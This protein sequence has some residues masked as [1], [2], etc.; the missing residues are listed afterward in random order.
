MIMKGKVVLFAALLSLAVLVPSAPA[1]INPN[2]TPV[3]LVNEATFILVLK[4]KPADDKNMAVAEV[5]KY[6]KGKDKA[7]QGALTFD[8]SQAIN[9]EYVEAL[10]K[11]LAEQGEE[12]VLMFVGKGENDEEVALLHMLGKW[13]SLGKTDKPTLFGM[14]SF[15]DKM[16]A[17]WAG[18]TDM[19]LLETELLLKYP[20]TDV[21]V[22]VGAQWAE[23]IELGNVKGKCA[24]LMPVDLDGKG[25]L[26]M[27]IACDQGDRLYFFDKDKNT[28]VDNA[29]KM[30]LASKSLVAAWGDFNGDGRMD[31]ASWDGKALAIWSQSGDGT[32]AAGEPVKA[33]PTGQ[34]LGLSAMDAGVPKKAGLLWTGAEG[35]VLLVPA[36]AGAFKAQ[37]L[38]LGAAKLEPL[39]KLSRCLVGDL[40]DDWLADVLQAGEQA[41]L[42][43]KGK[44]GGAF[45]DAAPCVVAL[46]KSPSAG[47]LGD[48]DMDGRLDVFCVAEDT[49]RLWHN[50][51]GMKFVESIQR[52]GEVA[53]ISKPGAI[54]GNVCDV[55][56][57]GLQDMFLVYGA[58]PDT[59]PQTFFNRGFR[60]TGH[61]HKID[62]TENSLLSDKERE[63][64]QCG[65]IAD[66]TDDGAQDL[67]VV[68]KN[69][70][71]FVFPNNV[72]DFSPVCLRVA[73]PVGADAVGPIRVVA[74]NDKRSLGAWDVTAGTAEAFLG[75]PEPGVT[76]TVKW[77]FPG[78]KEQKKT[79]KLQDKPVRIL[80]SAA[81]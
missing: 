43:F 24:D 79:V 67:A 28:F 74:S 8:V 50:Y 10:R 15:D 22:E 60:S 33:A 26:R 40:D 77:Q 51:P 30:K 81:E 14:F 57:D 69:G 32:F 36:D 55:N 25:K 19:L 75:Q 80:L 70:D 4:F 48:W 63:G 39:G 20:D 9:K 35:P 73:L 37:K 1:L 38:G 59:G 7:P 72:A 18:G 61:A 6:L 53:Y 16:Q 46:G 49:C 64:Q 52:S 45:A 58:N 31:L 71:L 68:L 44:G 3:N 13:I 42:F 17:T 41:S 47:F 21:P 2:F 62:I 27:F 12:P 56:N 5:V 11:V 78:G 29:A 76:L 34:C 23:K 65:Y 54:A 66:F